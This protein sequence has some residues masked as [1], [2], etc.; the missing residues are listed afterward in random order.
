MTQGSTRFRNSWTY[1]EGNVPA[2]VLQG[3]IFN[4]NFVNWTVDVLS[5]FDQKR[6]FDI[7]VGSPYMHPNNG[8]GFSVFPE[9]GAKCMVCLPSDSSPPFVA[10]FVMPVE[11][12]DMASPEAPAGTTSH[13]S[14]GAT[15]SGASF[16]GGRPIPKPGDMYLRTRDDN[17]VI[18]HRG[19]VLQLG[20]NELA[21][22]LYIPMQSQIMDV[23]QNYAHHNAGGSIQWLIGEGPDGGQP[24]Q[25][26]HTF[27][28]QAN[29][30]F[31]DVRVRCGKVS[32]MQEPPGELG[33]QKEIDAAGLGAGEDIILYE[34]VVA[35][36]GFNPVTGDLATPSVRDQTVFRFFFDRA[37]GTFLRCKGSLIV[38]TKKR[39]TV[40]ALEGIELET[41]GQFTAKAEGIVLDGGSF[42][43]IKGGSIRFAGGTQAVAHMGSPVQT[44][45]PYTPLPTPGPPVPMILSGFVKGGD[46]RVKVGAG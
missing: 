10:C 14:P 44:I 20:A 2:V 21:Q 23:S 28:V 17:F 1:R 31:A 26:G 22:R 24:T 5:Q 42:V 11:V 34:V 12:T 19:G 6:Y 32:A 18:L 37:G 45:F 39:L 27:R 33:N 41:E 15:T 16:A 25:Y 4:V 30:E 7:Q 8:E 13:A 3:T 38:S 46:S 36:D 35:K 29:S 43:D 40:R 9:V